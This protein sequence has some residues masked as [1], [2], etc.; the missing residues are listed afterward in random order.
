MLEGEAGSAGRR[1]I[2]G[3]KNWDNCHSII[4]KIYLKKDFSGVFFLALSINFIFI[5]SPVY[6]NNFTKK[7]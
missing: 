1:G 2:K 5:F 3:R 6:V 4:K 7:F